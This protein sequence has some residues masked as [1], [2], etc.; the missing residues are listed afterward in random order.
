LIL[1]LT[2]QL[3]YHNLLKLFIVSRYHTKINIL[4]DLLTYYLF[5]NH[6]SIE[7][8][9]NR[10]LEKM[11]NNLINQRNILGPS[12][13]SQLWS[14][15]SIIDMMNKVSEKLIG[16]QQPSFSVR[17]IERNPPN[18]KFLYNSKYFSNFYEMIQVYSVELLDNSKNIAGSQ[19]QQN[20]ILLK[21]VN[22][23]LSTTPNLVKIFRYSN[24]K[25][26][27]CQ[28]LHNLGYVPDCLGIKLK[29]RKLLK[30]MNNDKCIIQGISENNTLNQNQNP[31][32]ELRGR[33]LKDEIY[34]RVLDV[35]LKVLNCDTSDI[36]MLLNCDS[37]DRSNISLTDQPTDDNLSYV[38]QSSNTLLKKS[39]LFPDYEK[40]LEALRSGF[41]QDENK[42][43]NRMNE[44]IRKDLVNQKNNTIQNLPYYLIQ[45]AESGVTGVL[46]DIGS[47]FYASA[48]TGHNIANTNSRNNNR[49]NN[50][51][52]NRN[53][54]QSQMN[55]QNVLYKDLGRDDLL[56]TNSINV[57]QIENF[58]N[59]QNNQVNNVIKYTL[60]TVKDLTNKTIKSSNPFMSR[61]KDIVNIF[62][63][64]DRLFSS[65]IVIVVIAMMLYFIDITS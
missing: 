45:N 14:G 17:K 24:C 47:L 1:Q 5:N 65:G 60:D 54:N 52:N 26:D 11:S 35:G 16:I 41:R 50:Q 58:Q 21:L 49:N 63:R 8:I 62:T 38:E 2:S 30:K 40:N 44:Q 51:N 6:L 9:V 36:N 19:N 59:N 34:K 22:F 56:R 31:Q 3:Y 57:N 29:Y 64:E 33:Q 32:Q 18:Y 46:N 20:E 10:N 7:E 48:R 13:L 12:V 53:N 55:N 43:L 39:S 37:I 4:D 23:V 28:S 25:V 61:L 42:V 15:S 27:V